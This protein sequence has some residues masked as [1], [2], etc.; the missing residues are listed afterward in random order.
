ML[1]AK[2][3]PLDAIMREGR[4]RRAL[5]R[6]GLAM[7]NRLRSYIWSLYAHNFQ[8]VEEQDRPVIP[9]EDVENLFKKKEYTP[10]SIRRPPPWATIK[11]D[12][13]EK[14][15]SFLVGISMSAQKLMTYSRSLHADIVWCNKGISE[16]AGMLPVWEWVSGIRGIGKLGLGVL[17]AETGNL[18]FYPKH[19]YVWKRLGVAV[20]DGE[21]QRRVA[22]NPELAIRLGYN[23]ERRSVL[24]LTSQGL[25]KQN[26]NPD[27]SDGY[28]RGLYVERKAHEAQKH[29][30]LIP[31]VHHLRALRYMSKIFVK[32]L[33]QAWRD[34]SPM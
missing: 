17:I 4:E 23:P 19:Y 8:N 31:M 24:F 2:W 10:S 22:N 30:E 9:T 29:P 6:A 5:L 33:W 28:Y 25:M 14:L 7:E 20:I 18:S 32:H 13:W 26:K 34:H 1:E 15:V 16:A 21:R 12:E 3:D 27:G 11:Q